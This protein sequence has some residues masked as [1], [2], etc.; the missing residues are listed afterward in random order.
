[1]FLDFLIKKFVE[2][3]FFIDFLATGCLLAFLG[4]RWQQGCSNPELRH[5]W[6]I[7]CL[8]VALAVMLL[9]RLARIIAA[10]SYIWNGVRLAPALALRLGINIYPALDSGTITGHIYGSVAALL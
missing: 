5:D 6:T 3:S 2:P 4:K 10:P 8:V 7:P 9:S 1:M